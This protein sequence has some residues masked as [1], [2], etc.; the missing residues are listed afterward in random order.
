M[1]DVLTLAKKMERALRNGTGFNVTL[2]EMLAMSEIGVID[3]VHA[4]KLRELQARCPAKANIP[5]AT[6]G[7]TNGE[8]ASPPTSGK[9]PHIDPTAARSFIAALSAGA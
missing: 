3:T 2:D 4:A 8:T 1:G 9:S 6:I 5:T 7:S